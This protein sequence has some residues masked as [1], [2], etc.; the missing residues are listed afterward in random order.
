MWHVLKLNRTK[1]GK[2][3]GSC[4]GGSKFTAS[5]KCEKILGCLKTV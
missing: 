2:M 5:I 4:E 1:Y 3:L